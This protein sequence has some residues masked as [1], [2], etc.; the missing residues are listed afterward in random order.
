MELLCFVLF[1]F[2][3]MCAGRL[4]AAC[5]VT[6]PYR[7]LRRTV[8]CHCSVGVFCPILERC[9]LRPVFSTR[10]L[11]RWQRTQ[12]LLPFGKT[13]LHWHAALYSLLSPYVTW[14]V[15]GQRQSCWYLAQHTS[16]YSVMLCCYFASFRQ[17]TTWYVLRKS[18]V[19]LSITLFEPP[20]LVLYMLRGVLVQSPAH[21]KRP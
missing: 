14:S 12:K 15:K 18:V 13:R 19:M 5:N 10:H 20:R 1:F 6:A 17:R 3:C 21:V 9:L 16:V 8:S 7:E 2:F 4:V 11:E